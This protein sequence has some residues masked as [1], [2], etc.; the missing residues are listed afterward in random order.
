MGMS[1][2][3]KQKMNEAIL[4]KIGR[5]ILKRAI[6]LAPDDKGGLR[7]S[8]NYRIEGNKVIIYSPLD[9]AKDMEYGKPAGLLDSKEKEDLKDWAE[10][11]GLPAFPVIRKIEQE[12][13][14]VGTIENPLEVP[15]GTYRP[16]VRPAIYQMMPILA[17]E[18][19]EMFQ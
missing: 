12:G 8:L 9:Y 6:R 13:I 5:E 19:P 7:L 14:K 16:F 15:N 18:I 1:S 11:H 4:N 17:K 3:D 2:Q 10:R